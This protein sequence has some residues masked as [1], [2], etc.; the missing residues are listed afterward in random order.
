VSRNRGRYRGRRT[1]EHLGGSPPQGRPGLS[2]RAVSRRKKGGG[3]GIGE[4]REIMINRNE[5]REGEERE[6][7]EREERK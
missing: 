6:R 4:G 1:P 5:E 2:E 3:R 7:E